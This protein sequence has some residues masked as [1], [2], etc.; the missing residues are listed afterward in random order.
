VSQPVSPSDHPQLSLVHLVRPPAAPVQGKPPLL[1]QL[2]G[3]GSNERDLFSF[4]GLL[5]PRFLVLS[6]RALLDRGP[7]AYA[8][9][10]VQFLPQGFAIDVEQLRAS[11]DRVIQFV[12]EAVQA[13]GADRERVYFQ[14]FSQGAII[15]LTTML[16]SP[17]IVAGV[18]AMSGRI[19]Q[20]TVGW[21]APRKELVGV[22][23]L[24]AHGTEDDVIPIGY[25][26]YARDLLRGLP[27]DLTYH[28]YDMRHTIGPQAMRDMLA[29]LTARLDG[30]RRTTPAPLA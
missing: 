9:F 5:D 1:L 2:H 30:P 3:V 23:V 22:P 26:R 28:E 13:Y 11:R 20:E 25:A 15:S 19:P 18:A 10:D 21:I 17:A 7:D 29:W 4:A 16:S 27:V 12:D 24:L 14:G 8:W 6:V